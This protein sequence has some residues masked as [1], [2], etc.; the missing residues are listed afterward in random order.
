MLVKDV[1]KEE[2]ED[3]EN[4]LLKTNIEYNQIQQSNAFVTEIIK[5][6]IDKAN[7]RSESSIQKKIEALK[8]NKEFKK[9]LTEEKLRV[10]KEEANFIGSLP[11]WEPLFLE[12]IRL[13]KI[14]KK[15]S[16]ML[17]RNPV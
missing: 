1:S 13:T 6:M 7:F 14:W 17:L 2:A 3:F 9:N 11:N 5:A 15:P 10:I 4:I 8:N 16:N 12:I